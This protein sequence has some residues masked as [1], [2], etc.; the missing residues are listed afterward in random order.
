M[1]NV[2]L[3]ALVAFFAAWTLIEAEVSRPVRDPLMG[4]LYRIEDRAWA[5]YV[6]YGLSCAVCVGWWVTVVT[7]VV[8]WPRFGI[9]DLIA[10]NG[11][12]MLILGLDERITR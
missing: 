11:I 6:A 7:V 2:L 4:R 3:L 9:I 10:A 5:D 8:A 12:H 1:T